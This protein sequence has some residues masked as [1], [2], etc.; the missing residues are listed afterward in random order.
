MSINPSTRPPLWARNNA[1]K[2]IEL[3]DGTPAYI[4]LLK[5]KPETGQ[6]I[7]KLAT[8]RQLK[9]YLQRMQVEGRILITGAQEF[10]APCLGTLFVSDGDEVERNVLFSRIEYKIQRSGLVTKII[11][12]MNIPHHAFGRI[13]ERDLRPP[14]SV[15]RAFTCKEFIDNTLR[16]HALGDPDA[17]EKSFAIR[18]FDGFLVGTVREFDIGSDAVTRKILD[19]RTFL[20]ARDKPDWVRK[21][22]QIPYTLFEH[23]DRRAKNWA[24]DELADLLHQLRKSVAL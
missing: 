3:M 22:M 17:R 21:T 2:A 16:L 18:F 8:E 6:V 13:F 11:P 12:L 5:R 4:S 24:A 15:A 9:T 7:Q 20:N 23:S 14:L 10:I 19:V 1:R